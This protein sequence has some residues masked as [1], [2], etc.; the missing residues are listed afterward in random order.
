MPEDYRSP[1]VKDKGSLE[2]NFFAVMG[3]HTPW[4]HRDG[5]P[6]SEPGRDAI[7]L[8]ELLGSKTPWTKP[9]DPTLEELLDMLL[10]EA[11]TSTACADTSKVMAFTIE[12]ETKL[13]SLTTNRESLRKVLLGENRSLKD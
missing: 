1:C 11:V 5:D 8:I 12:G 6:R 4:C 9:Y 10:A 13:I 3:P 2:A 7:M